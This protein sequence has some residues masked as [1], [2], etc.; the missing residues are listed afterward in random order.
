MG[1]GQREQ[2]DM[3]LERSG[4]GKDFILKTTSLQKNI[5]CVQEHRRKNRSGSEDHRLRFVHVESEILD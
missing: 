2:K 4:V 1:V 5:H 3:M